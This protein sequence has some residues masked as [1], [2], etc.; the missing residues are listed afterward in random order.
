M[1]T[2]PP[3]PHNFDDVPYVTSADRSTISGG[4]CVN[5]GENEPLLA[6]G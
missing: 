3:P 6:H 4:G 1:Q 5:N 2:S